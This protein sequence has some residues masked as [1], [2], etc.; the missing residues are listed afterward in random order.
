MV[1]MDSALRQS[2]LQYYDERAPDYEEAYLLGTGTSSISDP[3]LFRAEAAILGDIVE[4]LSTGRLVDLAC[5]T[6]FWLPRYAARCSAI[7]LFDQSE[8]MLAEC[9]KKT[10]ALGIADRCSILRG[11]FFE[12]RPVLG[13]FDSALVG[14]FLSHLTEEQEPLLFD[15]LKEMLGTSGRFLLF[16]SAWSP[17][18]S[19]FNAKIERQTRCLNDG[20]AF[21]IYKRYCDLTDVV[22]WARNYGIVFRIEHF[23]SAFCALSGTFNRPHRAISP[24]LADIAGHPTAARAP[25]VRATGRI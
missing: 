4:R 22:R 5:G 12:S 20:T 3:E 16:D 14:F 13:R 15:S 1:D 23:G 10:L 18:R 25:A 2:M 6:A 11:D 7:T 17:E 8:S 24:A 21:E 9:R 19:R